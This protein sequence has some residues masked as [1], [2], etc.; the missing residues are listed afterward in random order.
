VTAPAATRTWLPA[1]ES[2]LPPLAI[3]LLLAAATEF[4][5][6]R[7]FTRTAIHLPG[8]QEVTVPYTVLTEAGRL[9]YYLATVL[10]VVLLAGAG[11]ALLRVHS[12]P[13]RLGAAA[14]VGY[15]G[16][17]AAAAAGSMDQ[18]VLAVASVASVLALAPWAAGRLSPLGRVPVVLY[19]SAFALAALFALG[20]TTGTPS[21]THPDVLLAAESLAL[22]FGVAAPL[23][24]GRADRITSIAAIAAGVAVCGL[25]AGNASTGKVLAL[26]SVGL[27]GYFPAITYGCA[28]AG[29]TY[30]AV[31]A[32]RGG[33]RL[34]CTGIVL[35]LLGG[36][37]LHSTYQTA[38]VVAGLAVFGTAGATNDALS[39]GSRPTSGRR[40]RTMTQ[41]ASAA[42]PTKA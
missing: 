14:I 26:W 31:A 22:A 25:L 42:I 7:I 36:V 38:L 2:I 16:I 1:T 15:G 11:A 29:A 30:A 40:E 12:A 34:L 3:G 9:G 35:L 5:L 10:L 39:R 17:A 27:A 19:L 6:L 24:T 21:L 41:S 33:A 4:L 8:I 37:G 18:A 28:A 32:W 20:Q 13:A 23:L